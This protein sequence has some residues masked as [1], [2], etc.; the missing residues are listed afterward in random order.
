[1]DLI[2]MRHGD[3][4]SVGENGITR[5][6]DRPLS[7]KGR[8]V[9]REIAD[10]LKALG[11]EPALILTS[12]LVRAAQTAAIAAECWNGKPVEPCQALACGGTPAGVVAA[13][14]SHAV[15]CLLAV[16]HIPDLGE[17]ASYLICGTPGAG[18]VFRKSGVCLIRFE[19]EPRAGAGS[20]EWLAPPC[21]LLG[22]G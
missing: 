22:K 1:V 15:P 17:L 6:A 5:D 18:I 9:T 12:P 11:V 14:R 4:F 10:A 3:A 2:L 21:L 19:G 8:K 13:F 7:V 16:G 20:L